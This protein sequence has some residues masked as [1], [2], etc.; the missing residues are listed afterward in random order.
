MVLGDF[1]TFFTDLPPITWGQYQFWKRTLKYHLSKEIIHPYLTIHQSTMHILLHPISRD[2][3]MQ[4]CL[5]RLG[6]HREGRHPVMQPLLIAGIYH[7]LFLFVSMGIYCLLCLCTW[8][9]IEIDEPLTVLSCERQLV[10]T[11]VCYMSFGAYVVH[12]EIVACR[13][14]ARGV[15]IVVERQVCNLVCWCCF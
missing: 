2:E 9:T 10:A 5:L 14:C 7:K 6:R 12:H 13:N 11:L 15:G 1:S 8:H 3:S 4:Q